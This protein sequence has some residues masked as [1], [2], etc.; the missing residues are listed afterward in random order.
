M[1]GIDDLEYADFFTFSQTT[2]TRGDR[3]KIF[4]E[5]CQTSTRQNSFIHRIVHIWNSITFDTKNSDTLN[6]FKNSVDRELK[7]L[8]FD[9]DE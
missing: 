3:Y 5:R 9:Y 8:M 4:I 1:H 2:F 7:N 6:G